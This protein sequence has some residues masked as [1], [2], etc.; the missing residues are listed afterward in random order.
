MLIFKQTYFLE[1]E[2]SA[3]KK[4]A[5]INIVLHTPA[6]PQRAKAL[7]QKVSEVHA[8]IAFNK[9]QALPINKM[10]KV[11]LFEAIKE[12]TTDN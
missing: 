1:S 7:A 9:V 11:K 10:D 2:V 3:L 6:D 5:P 12:L 8:S 4:Y